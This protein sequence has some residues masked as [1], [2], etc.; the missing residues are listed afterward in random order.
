MALAA[1]QYPATNASVG[2]SVGSAGSNSLLQVRLADG[3]A[4]AV[5]TFGH[6]PVA[7]NTTAR[8]R[9]E[10]RAGAAGGRTVTVF[11]NGERL[12][13]QAAPDVAGPVYAGGGLLFG[14]GALGPGATFRGVLGRIDVGVLL[15][16][17][18]DPCTA[19]ETCSDA[20]PN[21]VNYTCACR[22]GFLRDPVTRDCLQLPVSCKACHQIL[23]EQGSK[24]ADRVGT[25]NTCGGS[26]INGTCYEAPFAQARGLCQSIG[27]R[28]CTVQEI[29]ADETINTGCNFNSREV[30]TADPC[31]DGSYILRGSPRATLPTCTPHNVSVPVRCC[32]D[33]DPVPPSRQTCAQLDWTFADKTT[34]VCGASLFPLTLA[35][36][37]VNPRACAPDMSFRDAQL[38]CAANGG[39]LCTA[40]EM[41]DRKL[42]VNTGCLYDLN[43]TWSATLCTDS[44]ALTVQ[45]NDNLDRCQPM[46]GVASVRCCADKAPEARPV[47]PQSCSDLGWAPPHAASWFCPQPDAV[48]PG[49]AVPYAEAQAAC[50][51]LG[52]RLCDASELHFLARNLTSWSDSEC[53]ADCGVGHYIVHG[54]DNRY[55]CGTGRHAAA[56]LCCADVLANCSS[57]GTGSNDCSAIRREPC[58]T[59]ANKCGN[60]QAGLTGSPGPSNHLDCRGEKTEEER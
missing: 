43:F 8:W 2:L 14:A 29:Y 50:A 58:S 57:A 20:Y 13:R 22:P 12:G 54:L 42:T 38:F 5:L 30:W 40:A 27:A 31:P 48:P 6:A 45:V 3:A 15:P 59:A 28:L 36:Q 49:P 33:P 11:L 51:N 35:N 18:A 1:G 41:L 56:P 32:A 24:Y 23:Q 16:C 53:L 55:A 37:P 52:G 44:S 25:L 17:D 26:E 21:L 7:F 60:C 34:P 46:A 4:L 10:V 19:N 9:V 39:R 47:S